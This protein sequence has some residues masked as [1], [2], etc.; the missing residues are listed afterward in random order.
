MRQN[1]TE[2]S[3]SNGVN[4]VPKN[5]QGL[6][7]VIP[8]Q[9]SVALTLAMVRNPTDKTL[10]RPIEDFS[11]VDYIERSCQGSLS[12]NARLP[13]VRYR[14]V[15]FGF[16]IVSAIF[17]SLPLAAWGQSQPDSAPDSTLSP[18]NSSS[19][20]ASSP[21]AKPPLTFPLRPLTPTPGSNSNQVV[22]NG[23]RFAIPWTQGGSKFW[24]LSD[25][26][27][28]QLG[29][30][31]LLNSDDPAIQPIIWKSGLFQENGLFL[32]L[33]AEQTGQVR[34]LNLQPLIDQAGWTLQRQGNLLQIQTPS[35]LH[36]VNLLPG[37]SQRPSFS[38]RQ[39]T[40]AKGL[41][42]IQSYQRVGG[43]EFPVT[44]VQID[45]QEPGLQLRPI[46]SDEANLV[47]ISRLDATVAQQE[48][49]V[50][51]NG[52]F[53][54]RN[55]KT[56]LGAIRRD[57]EWVSGPV[58]NRGVMGWNAA[59]QIVMDRLILQETLTTPTGTFASIAL[60][61]GYVK[62]G[63]SR[64]TPLWGKT[65]TPLTDNEVLIYV[66]TEGE[67]DR[68]GRVV[69]Q[70]LTGKA[71]TES[72]PILS[73]TLSRTLSQSGQGYLLV[74]R[75]NRTGAAQFPIGTTVQL[76]QQLSS[77]HL[78]RFP[79]ILGAGPLLLQN[80]RVVLDAKAEGFSPAFIREQAPRSVAAVFPNG[81]FSLI[82]VHE[83]IGGKGPTLAELA[84]LLQAM[85]A[86]QALNLDGGSSTQLILG[87]QMINR[88]PSTAARV[89]NGLGVFLP[90]TVPSEALP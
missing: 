39:I 46:W 33:P 50:G 90:Q 21:P 78:S 59:G 36:T 44:Q 65:Y 71:G 15:R 70:R 81:R 2:I 3:Q 73:S 47:G 12:R 54:N 10:I 74:A 20:D 19:P 61:S 29:G 84:R 77:S 83:R 34:Y 8:K 49:A 63:F 17:A 48:A 51:I 79:E 80:R 16:G 26:G 1:P 18:S 38:P 25:T 41:Q 69:E 45:L 53:F 7:V 6:S 82:T 85:G 11:P 40:W 4:P 86:V 89:H 42:W 75:S 32:E 37:H 24:G 31:E 30:I 23:I 88:P 5:F 64:Y 68:L 55:N 67:G 35:I 62:A 60:N 52:G 56:P 76:S 58:L 87:G 22:V 66:E 13:L 14:M 43:A 9:P 28:E 72:F 27:I 57:G